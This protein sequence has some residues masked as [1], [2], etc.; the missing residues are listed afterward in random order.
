MKRKV[1]SMRIGILGAGAI[2]SILSDRLATAGHDVMI[3]N[4]RGPETISATALRGGARAVEA[5][6][7]V[8][9]VDVLILS[10]PL[11]RVPD[12]APLVTQAPTGA[13]VIDT[14]NYYPQRDQRIASIDNGQTESEWVAEQLG[15]PIVKA[16]NA[17]GSGPLEAA[18]T[19]SG[20]AERIAIPV[21]GDN[22]DAKRVTM[23]LIAQTGLDVV[24]AGS[25]AESWRQQPGTPV[26]CTARPADEIAALLDAA[27]ATAAPQRRDLV[28]AAVQERIET[29][30]SVSA[31][32]LTQL[33]RAVY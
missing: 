14:S 21:A 26:Y 11:H 2:G 22:I 30:G 7:A 8:R 4:S 16:W 12:L 19:E 18:S 29:D 25:L 6:D 13:I 33:N 24:D 3:A 32:Y 10:V 28:M 31:D 23:E 9:D 1:L 20:T 5:V 27:N 17:V 15:R